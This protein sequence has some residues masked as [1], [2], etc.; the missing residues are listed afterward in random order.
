MGYPIPHLLPASALHDYATK[1]PK[2][3]VIGRSKAANPK[4]V[5][6]LSRE[7][8]SAQRV[9]QGSR[10]IF[11]S[12]PRDGCCVSPTLADMRHDELVCLGK[13][14]GKLVQRCAP[15]SVYFFLPGIVV[16][17]PP[18]TLSAATCAWPLYVALCSDV[19]IVNS[20]R[21]NASSWSRLDAL[22]AVWAR[23]PLYVLPEKYQP[24]MEMSDTP[25]ACESLAGENQ[26][27]GEMPLSF[28][29]EEPLT[30]GRPTEGLTTAPKF[31]REL[32]DRAAE[33]EGAGAAKVFR[34]TLAVRTLT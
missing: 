6:V 22:L 12:I 5:Q 17:G 14:A 18:S 32:A 28:T 10:L 23:K 1:F 3:V 31:L 11:T 16:K 4:G 21:W 9:P 33:V 30:I 15:R 2:S 7:I 34:P 20:E 24:A 26:K 29:P 25:T 8:L 27:E 13:L 19:I